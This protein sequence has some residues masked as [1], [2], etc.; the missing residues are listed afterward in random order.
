MLN[1]LFWKRLRQGTVLALAVYWIGLF[2]GT[3]V[4]VAQ[5]HLES[6][7]K[8]LHFLAYAGLAL[9]LTLVVNWRAAGG[10]R[11]KHLVL[12]VVGLAIFGGFD[13]LTQPLVNRQADWFDWIADVSGV[14]FGTALGVAVARVIRLKGLVGQSAD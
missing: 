11:P 12:I 2:L 7:D 6:N 4:P 9:L 10:L 1:A 5:V 8:L 3:H 14:V 13:E